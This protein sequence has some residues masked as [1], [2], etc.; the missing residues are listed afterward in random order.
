MQSNLS[1]TLNV[2]DFKFGSDRGL[3]RDLQ[4]QQNKKFTS[5][6]ERVDIKFQ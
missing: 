2:T 3:Y 6:S 1:L 4:F 5:K